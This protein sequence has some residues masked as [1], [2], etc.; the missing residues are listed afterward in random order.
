MRTRASLVTTI[1]LQFPQKR[2]LL[3]LLLCSYREERRARCVKGRE[4]PWNKADASV[5]ATEKYGS[6]VQISGALKGETDRGERM[7]YS[8]RPHSTLGT[9]MRMNSHLHSCSQH[10]HASSS[11]YRLTP[12]RVI[13]IRTSL[14]SG[15]ALL[16]D[17]KQD[18]WCR[19]ANPALPRALSCRTLPLEKNVTIRVD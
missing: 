8:V 11:A 9:V 18:V 3:L 13:L 5:T 14:S 7:S 1:R 19:V 16:F 12:S 17:S 6:T 10:N 2:T 4:R 15:N